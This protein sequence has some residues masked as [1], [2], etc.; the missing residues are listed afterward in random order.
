MV[1]QDLLACMVLVNCKKNVL[2]LSQR[3]LASLGRLGADIQFGSN[4]SHQVR[5]TGVGQPGVICFATASLG[6]LD[7]RFMGGSKVVSQW[8]A[9]IQG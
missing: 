5:A 8:I 1:Q 2:T 4:L 9:I 3:E 7:V 6:R